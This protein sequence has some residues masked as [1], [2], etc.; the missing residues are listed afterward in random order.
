V[1]SLRTYFE[2]PSSEALGDAD[3]PP[4]VIFEN[5]FLDCDTQRALSADCERPSQLADIHAEPIFSAARRHTYVGFHSHKASWLA[6]V[7]GRKAWFLASPSREMPLVREPWEYVEARPEGVELVVAQPGDVL[8]VP[9]GWWHATWNLD[10]FVVGVG[11]ESPDDGSSLEAW[12]ASGA[13]SGKPK[14]L[15][16][17]MLYLAA[18]AGY[19]D[20]L[21]SLLEWLGPMEDADE[22]R[23]YLLGA[24]AAGAA[25]SGHLKALELLEPFS[26]RDGCWHPWALH[27]AALSGQDATVAWLLERGAATAALDSLNESEWAPSHAFQDGHA[28]TALHAAAWSGHAS[29]VKRLLAAG[30]DASTTI[31]SGAAEAAVTCRVPRWRPSVE[32][33]G[34][35]ALHLAARRGHHEVVE[36]LLSGAEGLVDLPDAGQAQNT[37]SNHNNNSNSH[38]K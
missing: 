12:R 9:E 16:Q 19:P 5:S 6:Q 20:V 37:N 21:Q 13:Q 25:I 32:G 3:R 26:R 29:V 36:A 27:A 23:P 8:F 15:T 11:W 35:T 2:E 18:R 22:D 33:E 10:D 14:Y 31:A 38:K 30:A 17:E 28:W 4:A 24:V 34:A 7:Q 1:V